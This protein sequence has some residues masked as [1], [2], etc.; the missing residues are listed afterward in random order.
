MGM[1]AIDKKSLTKTNI[2]TKSTGDPIDGVTRALQCVAVE[3]C[4]EQSHSP[5]NLASA[6]AVEVSSLLEHFQW[7]TDEQSRDLPESTK[8]SVATNAADVLLYLIQTCTAAQIDLNV[9]A[10]KILSRNAEKRPV[11]Y[12]ISTQNKLD[13]P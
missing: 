8:N 11:E 5:K 13:Q 4:R 6:L 9:V 7:L 12:S 3:I 10:Q 1:S 2:R